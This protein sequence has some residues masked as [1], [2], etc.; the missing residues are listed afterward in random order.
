MTGEEC[1]L[2]IKS[3]GSNC[4]IDGVVVHCD[5]T[6]VKVSTINIPTRGHTLN[7]SFTLRNS[8]VL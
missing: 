1:T 3:N 5:P 2:L 4:P 7:H 8:M 6:G